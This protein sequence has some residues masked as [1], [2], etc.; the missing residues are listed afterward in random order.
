MNTNKYEQWYSDLVEDGWDHTPIYKKVSGPD[1]STEFHKDGFTIHIYRKGDAIS[2]SI[3]AWGPDILAIRLPESYNFEALQD[4]LKVCDYCGS[5]GETKRIGFA[6]RVCEQC[7][8]E[9]VARV[10]YRGW[11]N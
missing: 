2:D 3:S 6:G 11:N 1:I 5:V 8:K 4:A 7:H 9:N 10:E